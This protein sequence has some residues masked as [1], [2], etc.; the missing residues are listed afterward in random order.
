MDIAASEPLYTVFVFHPDA[1]MPG[2]MLPV[3]MAPA[4]ASHFFESLAG[5]DGQDFTLIELADVPGVADGGF[6][7][8]TVGALR[9]VIMVGQGTVKKAP[10][11]T[12]RIVPAGADGFPPGF[13]GN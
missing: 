7:R 1:G 2:N 10:S 11:P 5:A 8:V 13:L 4:D 6:V 3:K 12:A 9:R